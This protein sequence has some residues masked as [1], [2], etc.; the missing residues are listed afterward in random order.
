MWRIPH[1]LDNRLTD[2]GKVVSPTHLPRFT[3]KKYFLVL[4]S[5]TCGV[6]PRVIVQLEGLGK[7]QKSCD[8]IRSRTRDFPTCSIVP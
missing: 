6:S 8:L 3:P 2:G 4:I 1:Y 5:V 7:L